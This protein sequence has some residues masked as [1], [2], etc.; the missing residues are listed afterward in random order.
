MQIS[1][2]C[3]SATMLNVSS[4]I[5]FYLIDYRFCKKAYN[6]MQ[7]SKKVAKSTKS[8]CLITIIFVATWVP[9]TLYVYISLFCSQCASN[10]KGL[11]TVA[12]LS[13]MMVTKLL[14]P[15]I[16]ILQ[17]RDFKN[18]V[19]STVKCKCCSAPVSPKTSVFFTSFESVQDNN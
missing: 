11:L 17:N 2:R 1:F 15:W 18:A 19:K 8:F 12:A 14:N 3:I 10:T 4:N 16:Y 5:I 7:K 9:M 6:M 13:I